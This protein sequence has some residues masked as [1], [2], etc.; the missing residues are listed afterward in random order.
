MINGDQLSGSRT[1][2]WEMYR[3][4][5]R[6][7]FASRTSAGDPAQLAPFTV[8]TSMPAETREKIA[9]SVVTFGITLRTNP[10][11]RQFRSDIGCPVQQIDEPTTEA[12]VDKCGD[13]GRRIQG[14]EFESHA[15]PFLFEALGDSL[16]IHETLIPSLCADVP[17]VEGGL[18]GQ[19][20][21]SIG[22]ENTGST[23][24]TD[25]MSVASG[26]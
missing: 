7:S 25:P 22:F 9:V 16:W 19:A 6:L 15:A 10:A 18:G 4:S 12:A 20:P 5:W 17:D 26:L 14:K 21:Q 8:A 2:D 3:P 23:A 11:V 13:M 1:I 24:Q